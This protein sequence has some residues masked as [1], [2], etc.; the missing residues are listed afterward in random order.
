MSF[1]PERPTCFL[2]IGPPKTGSSTISHFVE[3]NA[4]TLESHGVFIPKMPALTGRPQNGHGIFAN[5]REIDGS[6]GL[7]P[8]AKLWPELEAVA[9]EGKQNILL[10]SEA[11]THAFRHKDRLEVFLKFFERHDYNVRIIAYLRDQPSSLNSTYVQTQKRLM[12]RWTF[13]EFLKDSADRG[14]VDPWRWLEHIIDNPRLSLDVG[15]FEQAVKGGLEADFARRIGMPADLELKTVKVRNPNAGQKAVYAAQRILAE[16]DED[17]FKS[18]TYKRVYRRFRD[19]FEKLGWTDTPY[20]ALDDETYRKIRDYYRDANERFAEKYLGAPWSEISPDRSYTKSVFDPATA[21]PDDLREI[22]EVVAD[23]IEAI[24]AGDAETPKRKIKKSSLSKQLRKERRATR[25]AAREAA[26][27][28]GKKASLLGDASAAAAGAKKKSGKALAGAAAPGE[29]KK[30]KK[31]EAGAAASAGG[32]SPQ[33]RKSKI[34][35]AARA[36]GKDAGRG[37]QGKKRLEA[38]AAAE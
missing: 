9:S 23:I 30:K 25:R 21:N 20:V 14:R 19:H 35:R 10:T 8:G 6:G 1:R 11:F 37:G 29:K 4:A 34:D 5:V 36:G 7:K 31:L 28:T 16:I 15:S 18:P 26:G 27:K 22:D 17:I 24:K 38:P 2:H 33:A 3:N 13:D 32:E 12:K